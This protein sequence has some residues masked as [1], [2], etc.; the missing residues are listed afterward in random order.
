[1]G[2]DDTLVVQEFG[3]DFWKLQQGIDPKKQFTK[4]PYG[5]IG[6]FHSGIRMWHDKYCNTLRQ[7]RANFVGKDQP[8]MSRTGT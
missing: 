8:W 3:T 7:N 1:M 4:V 2:L 5:F 6:G